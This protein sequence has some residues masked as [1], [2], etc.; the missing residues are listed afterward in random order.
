M[1]IKDNRFQIHSKR[2]L[3][4]QNIILWRS[5]ALRPWTIHPFRCLY[6][7][8]R[9]NPITH[10]GSILTHKLLLIIPSSPCHRHPKNQFAASTHRQVTRTKRTTSS[11]LLLLASMSTS[12]RDRSSSHLT[13][14]RT[15]SHCPNRYHHRLK[16]RA[17]HTMSQRYRPQ[18]FP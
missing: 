1:K 5:Q 10:L 7:R 17:L 11:R 15:P 16:R 8:L 9:M 2:F 12:N 4:Q 6:P 3:H 13:P 14:K 18:V